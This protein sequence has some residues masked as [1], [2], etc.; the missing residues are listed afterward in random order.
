MEPADTV[1][2]LFDVVMNGG[3]LSALDKLLSQSYRDHSP[4]PGLSD[5]RDGVRAKIQAMRAAFTDL[6]FTLDEIVEQG[7][8]AA[9]RWHW[10]GTHTGEFNGVAPTGRSVHVDGMDFYRIVDGRIAEHW[11][12]VDKFGLMSQLEASA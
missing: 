12:V 1:R 3:D 9:A 7:R 11:D 10:N 5:H 6:H 2:R 8:T 4:A